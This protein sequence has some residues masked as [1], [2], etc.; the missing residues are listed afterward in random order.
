MTRHPEPEFGEETTPHPL[1]QH[2]RALTNWLDTVLDVETGLREILLQSHYETAMDGLDAVLDVETGLAAIVHTSPPPPVQAPGPMVT[3]PSR[4]SDEYF[5]QSVS[6][7]LRMA[8]RANTDVA[9]SHQAFDRARN[10][11]RALALNLNLNRALAFDLALD[12]VRDLA[13]ALARNLD[14]VLDSDRCRSLVLV[15]TPDRARLDDDLHRNRHNRHPT[16]EHTF[17]EARS[18]VCDVAEDL[19]ALDRV[20]AVDLALDRA[21]D[22]GRSLDLAIDLALDRA[23]TLDI[24]AFLFDFRI[25]EIR[26]SIGLMLGRELPPLG[27]DSLAAFL[28]D[29]TTSDLRTADLVGIDL[30]GVR[31]S[32]K[33]TW[34]PAAVDID[35]LKTRSEETPAG[36]GIWVVQSGGAHLRDFA[37][38]G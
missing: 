6:P 13:Q 1:D 15:C 14:G 24:N 5:L 35:D 18:L 34:W 29:F 32:V 9:I 2:Q 16:V 31:W 38:R 26:R 11:N 37:D 10:R 4:T 20:F 25:S 8:L 3:S 27:M 22:L 33:G 17:H 30:S 36:S 19:R 12:L 28:D 7:P 23:I 21:V